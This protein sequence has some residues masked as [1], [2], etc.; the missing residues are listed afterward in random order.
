MTPRVRIEALDINDDIDNLRHQLVTCYHNKLPVYDGEMNNILGIFHIRKALHH[1]E[2]GSLTHDEIRASLTKP[3]FIPSK[4]R[5]LSSSN[6]FKKINNVWAWWS[7]STA[8]C[9]VF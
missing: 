5:F 8:K 1:L 9:L 6:I 2:D 7:M 4:P 3:Y